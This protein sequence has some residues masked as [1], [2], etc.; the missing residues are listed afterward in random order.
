MFVYKRTIFMLTTLVAFSGCAFASAP[1]ATLFAGRSGSGSGQ[2]NANVLGIVTNLSTGIAPILA[3]ITNSAFVGDPQLRNLKTFVPVS[4]VTQLVTALPVVNEVVSIMMAVLGALVSMGGLGN[5][6]NALSSFLKA[7]NG[8]I[9][10][11]SR[12]VGSKIQNGMATSLTV[13]GLSNTAGLLGIG[14]TSGA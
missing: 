8:V 12:N 5:I 9:P 14:G 3:G 6:D 4:G 13:L 2:H 1:S 11:I 10:G 7:L